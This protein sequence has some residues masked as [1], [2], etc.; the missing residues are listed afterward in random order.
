MFTLFLRGKSPSGIRAA[1]VRRLAALAYRAAG[2]RGSAEMSVTSVDDRAM[3]KLNR[4]HRGKDKTTD[5][6]SFGYEG[7]ADFPVPAKAPRVLGD[8]FISLPQVR[9]QA[10][11]IGRSPRQEFA[12]VVVHGA[13]HLMGFDHDTPARERRMFG[14][15]HEILLR[16]RIF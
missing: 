2:G 12:I 15:Q 1:E 10:K 3:R 13:L 16:L 5:V 14:L 11:R 7:A 9:R 6:L 8:V 4:R